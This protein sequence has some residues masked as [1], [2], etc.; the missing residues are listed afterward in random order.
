M[1]KLDK[2]T[3]RGFKFY[4]PIADKIT[5]YESSNAT[6]AEL[7]IKVKDGGDEVITD[8]TLRQALE[9][10]ETLSEAVRNHYQGIL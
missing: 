7:W 8:L 2:F 1:S 5:V 4:K 10:S 9:L 3:E 6:E